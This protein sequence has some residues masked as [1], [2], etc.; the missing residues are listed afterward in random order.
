MNTPRINIIAALG[1]R[2]RAIG[3]D[4]DLLWRIPGDLPRVKQLTMGHPLLM[5]SKT[6]ESIGRPLPG[7]TNIVVTNDPQWSC[8][9]ITV[10]Y[11]IDEALDTA[12]SL[13]GEEV[14][15][16]GGGSV[17]AQTIDRADRLYLTLVDD[18]T[19]G[20]AFFPEYTHLPFIEVARE[21][22]VADGLRFA[23]V[24]L[25]RSR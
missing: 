12:R 2:T 20:D 7:R 3:K 9:G 1:A 22:H 11:S 8:E 5:G 18:D 16:F 6:F 4:N 10:C 14:F 15:V 17:Y 24:T 23:W 13:D 19:P 21:D 25:E